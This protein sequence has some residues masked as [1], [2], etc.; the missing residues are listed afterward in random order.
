VSELPPP[1]LPAWSSKRDG[2]LVPF[3]PDRICQALFAASEALGR[4]DAFLARELTDSV[5]HFLALET[6]GA[7]ATTAQVA[8]VAIK[9]VREL[10]HPALARIFEAGQQGKAHSR[11]AKPS[12]S[13]HF[14]ASDPPEAVV[15][16]CLREYSQRAIFSRDLISAQADGL[17][18]L[19]GL[20][21][22][23][24]LAGWVLS[25]PST[26]PR[27]LGELLMESRPLAG[28]F[29]VLDGPEHLLTRLPDA[30]AALLA[31]QLGRGLAAMG[32]HAW[33]NLGCAVPPAWAEE[34]PGG[35]LFGSLAA[36]SPGALA[37]GSPAIAEALLACILEDEELRQRTSILWHVGE[38]DFGPVRTA[39]GAGLL[40]AARAAAAGASVT[41]LFDRPRRP[42]AL[43]PG[44]DRQHPAVLLAV[45]L[46]LPRLA[47][48]LGPG[49]ELFLSKLASLARLAL[50]AG[51]QKRAFLRRHGKDAAR[52]G[53]LLERARL[54]V[55]PVGLEVAV[56]RL[57]G[58]GLC[59]GKAGLELACQIVGRLAEVLRSEG[60]SAGLEVC[61]DGPAGNM[62]EW[63][64]TWAGP[65]PEP[66]AAAGLTAWAP[67][68][69]PR[70]QLRAAEALHERAGR[71]IAVV[72]TRSLPAET[73]LELLHFAWRQTALAAV[74]FRFADWPQQPTLPGLA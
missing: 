40:Y 44:L 23:L 50:S 47:E 61:L 21:A 22:P 62:A 38:R 16:A 33:V 73:L 18:T 69:S 24:G 31:Q 74:R 58:S 57:T 1:P 39:A 63:E 72:L 19:M 71:G 45:G 59:D 56:H 12:A 8:E 30:D 9:V 36:P 41:F 6:A 35:P 37:P 54:V 15:A 55:V 64:G 49:P 3:E 53:F 7:A 27:G 43:G 70:R 13:F 65:L 17:L 25:P 20:E 68:A 11:P 34:E 10:G 14:A 48:L 2:R 66:Q 26:G 4:P 28:S 32:L 42:I 67:A 29:V 5:L 51:R 46:H 52:R 60:A